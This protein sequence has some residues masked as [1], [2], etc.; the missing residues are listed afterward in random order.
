MLEFEVENRQFFELHIN[1]RPDSYY[2]I[3][4]VSLAIDQA[5]SDA[6][7]DKAYQYLVRNE[8]HALVARVNLAR[9]KRRHFHCAELGYRVAWSETGKG[10]ARE[11]VRQAMNQAFG[12]HR[13]VRVE[14]T[15]RPE[16]AGSVQVLM[17]NGFTKY[18]R[19]T[20]SFQLG[21]TWYDLLHFERRV[22]A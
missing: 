1:A 5:A 21:D 6:R 14:A 3:D 22:S 4:G 2:S 10:Y 17:G 16:N 19:S 12:V 15:T 9:V 11:A 20:R 8:A 18:G 13:L 7:D